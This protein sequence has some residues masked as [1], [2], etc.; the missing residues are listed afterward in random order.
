MVL[1]PDRRR[2]LLA[3]GVS[4]GPVLGGVL[5]VVLLL[6]RRR[7]RTARAEPE[8][9]HGAD[10]PLQNEV[11]VP[12]ATPQIDMSQFGESMQALPP[13]VDSP[14]QNPV[15]GGVHMFPKGRSVAWIL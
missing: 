10:G 12:L 3:L 14:L 4:G 7:R 5:V 8:D 9:A 15:S 13:S 1:G 11:S 2:A 6:K